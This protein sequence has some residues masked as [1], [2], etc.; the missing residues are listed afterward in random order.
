MMLTPV[1]IYMVRGSSRSQTYTP[2]ALK[3]ATTPKPRQSEET[4]AT[5]TSATRALRLGRLLVDDGIREGERMVSSGTRRCKTTMR[6]A[7]SGTQDLL[8]HC[9]TARTLKTVTVLTEGSVRA[10]TIL[11]S[12]HSWSRLS[13]RPMCSLD[14][15]LQH[16]FAIGIHAQVPPITHVV[17]KKAPKKLASS[18]TNAKYGKLW[19]G[20]VG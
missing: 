15:H 9:T 18:S 2:T 13:D 16:R 20:M 19:T 10:N 6:A 12:R 5:V 3:R 17:K 1:S 7:E 4:T 8:Q 14:V 11:R